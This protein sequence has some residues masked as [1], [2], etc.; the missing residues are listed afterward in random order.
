SS[1]LSRT[2]DTPPGQPPRG[3]RT[4]R[5][6]PWV[7]SLD[8][9]AASGPRVGLDSC[10]RSVTIVPCKND[11]LGSS[12]VS[13]C[14]GTTRGW[15]SARPTPPHPNPLP[16]GEGPVFRNSLSLRER[17]GVRV[18][19]VSISLGHYRTP[20]P[21]TRDRIVPTA[22][23]NHARN[24]RLGERPGFAP[25]VR[26]AGLQAMAESPRARARLD[27]LVLHPGAGRRL[28][29]GRLQLDA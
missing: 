20:C 5:I 24:H 9:R 21:A 17:V 2:A 8:I 3:T 4:T 22:R 12:V 28:G 19:G 15:A 18:L 27:A 25:H 1:P 13:R 26:L 10:A 16:P 6:G 29:P 23:S 7:I 11:S 14:D